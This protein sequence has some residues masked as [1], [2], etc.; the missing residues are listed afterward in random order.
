[1]AEEEEEQLTE[2]Q[3]TIDDLRLTIENP[4]L[5]SFGGALA[6]Q[7]LARALYA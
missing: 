4:L 3:L 5:A 2:D 1:V 6:P 7:N